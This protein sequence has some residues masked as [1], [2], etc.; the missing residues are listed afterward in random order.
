MKSIEKYILLLTLAGVIL[1]FYLYYTDVLNI[2]TICPTDGCAKV[3]NSEYSRFLG[4]HVSLWGIAYYLFFA[5]LVLF[6]DALDI[7][8]KYYKLLLGLTV[9]AG[10]AFTVYLRI[11]EFVVIKAICVWCWGSVVIVVLLTILYFLNLKS[12]GEKPEAISSRI[13]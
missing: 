3:A 11:V 5:C 1:S 6:K 2:S 13:A 8:K 10:V 4:V 12:N 7:I 9:F